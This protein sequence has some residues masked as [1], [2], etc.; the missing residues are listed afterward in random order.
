MVQFRTDSRA[1][2]TSGQPVNLTAT[3]GLYGFFSSI[4]IWALYFC[5]AAMASSWSLRHFSSCTRSCSFLISSAVAPG[6]SF[7]SP[8]APPD[9][10]ASPEA[11]PLPPGSCPWQPAISIDPTTSRRAGSRMRCSWA[12]VS[13]FEVQPWVPAITSILAERCAGGNEKNGGS[14][15]G[16]PA[17]KEMHRRAVCATN[18]G[19]NCE[20]RIK[21]QSGA[22][23][24][25][26]PE[27]NCGYF[28]TPSQRS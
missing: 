25:C 9:L 8:P 26:D 17:W 3:T 15:G 14:G 19:R 24:Q 1:L 22:P 4:S 28:R 5:N 20:G 23:G 16:P 21:G 6:G 10:P 18:P 27:D 12:I 2:S 11:P 13:S 7:D